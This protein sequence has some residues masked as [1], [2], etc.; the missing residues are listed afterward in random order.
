MRAFTRLI[1][2]IQTCAYITL[3]SN[4]FNHIV[5]TW[6]WLFFRNYVIVAGTPNL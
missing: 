1:K 4:V 6:C 2:G 5:I 3:Q